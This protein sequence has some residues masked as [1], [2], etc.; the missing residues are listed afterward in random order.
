MLK[1][2][3]FGLVIA[4]A[5]GLGSL[6]GAGM[7]RYG[8]PQGFVLRAKAEW[9]AQRPHEA[10]L[11]TPL[12][13]PALPQAQLQDASPTPTLA[14]TPTD[15]PSPT[16]PAQSPAQVATSTEVTS[17]EVATP[18][19][20]EPPTPTP[21]LAYAPAAPLAELTGFVHEW[22][23]WNNCAPATLA[24]DLS[25]YG[26][27]LTQADI[28]DVLRPNKEDKHVSSDE[29]VGYAQTQGLH[30]V[31]RVSGTPD[32]MRLLISNGVPV[33]I[34][35]WHEPA[36]NDG[37]GHY[38]LLMG[39]DDATQ[40]WLLYDSLS[41]TA[42]DPSAPYEPLRVSY[43]ELDYLWHVMDYRYVVVYSD[44]QAATV[45]SI[46][47]DQLDDSTMWRQALERSAADVELHPDDAFAWFDLGTNRLGLGDANG[48]AEAYD[49]A[50]VIGL[51]WRMLW[52][53]EGPLE[54]YYA[55]GRYDEVITLADATLAVTTD[56]EEIHYW[57]GLALEA[58]GQRDNAIASLQLALKKNPGYTAAA[59]AL[60]RLED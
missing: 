55:V 34:A 49:Q 17:P 4:M 27:Q 23:T 29:L 58:M 51:P 16:A 18:T 14:S 52:Y 28:G 9:Y 8:G 24:M 3:L 42:T 1:R 6:L 47:G 48:A 30:A 2:L 12:P 32:V 11:P 60:A 54:A 46:L 35:T 19:L 10:Y 33:I 40:E 13:T 50:R 39:Y 53:Q 22:Q 57:K 56:V 26:L 45:E 25:H 59:E 21:P 38:R 15:V 43:D 37:M 31:G 20:A 7:V 36:P 41:G 44:E 5:I